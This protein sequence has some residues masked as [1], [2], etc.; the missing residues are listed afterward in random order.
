MKNLIII[1]A[2]KFGREVLSWAVDAMRN[3]EQWRFKGF[4]D[5]RAHALDGFPC[6]AKILGSPATYQPETDD[7]F[8]AAIGEPAPKY[9]YCQP[10]LKKGAVFANL[11]HPLAN[12]GARVE[13]G[14]GVIISPFCNLTCDL[15]IGSFVTLG[16]F[17]GVAHDTQVGDWCQING[18]CGINGN[19]VLEE[20][21]FLG[22][23]SCILPDARV[24]A[25]AYV[26]AG[27]VVLRRVRPRTKVFGNPA[28]KIG[29]VEDVPEA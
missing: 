2:G 28:Q 4:L 13:L 16:V 23:H 17:S 29:E 26:G 24:G 21:V 3:G 6:D 12:V 11:I 18:H 19:A 1:N 7:V 15:R 10:L 14:Q 5:D 22:A 8:L 20:G 9:R 27:S 25:W